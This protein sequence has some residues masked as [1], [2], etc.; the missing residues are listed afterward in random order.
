MGKQVGKQV[1]RDTSV[2]HGSVSSTKRRAS[3]ELDGGPSDLIFMCRD[4]TLRRAEYQFYR[5][6]LLTFSATGVPPDRPTLRT[7]ARRYGIPLEATMA[8]MAQQDLVQRDPSTAAIRAAYP[9][10]S[11]PTAHVVTLPTNATDAGDSAEATPLHLYA[12]C[13]LDALGIPLMLHRDAVVTSVDPSTGEAIRVMVRQEHATTQ[14]HD[15]KDEVGELEG[16]SAQWEPST[17]VVFARPEDHECE[18]GVAAGSCCPVT[19]FFATKQQAQRWAEHHGST[20]DVVLTQVEALHRANTLFGACWNAFMSN[21]C[22]YPTMAEALKI[23]A[24]S[25]TRDVRALSCCAS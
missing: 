11:V 10:S 19:N 8:R 15:V 14:S 12:M 20:E 18:G 1:Q 2:P 16:W 21:G 17:A 9:F 7:L 4:A 5:E 3:E 22:R 23:A 6:I 24:I 13:A 25:F